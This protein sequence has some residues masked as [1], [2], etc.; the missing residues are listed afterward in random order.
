LLLK[1]IVEQFNAGALLL[2]AFFSVR[3][4]KSGA[5]GNDAPHPAQQYRTEEL[6]LEQA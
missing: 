4:V 3:R 1:K 5:S 2:P 6:I